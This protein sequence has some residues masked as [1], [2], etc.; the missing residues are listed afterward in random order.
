[1]QLFFLSCHCKL[2][3]FGEVFGLL[4]RQNIKY[5]NMTF[6]EYLSFCEGFE[7]YYFS[8]IKWCCSVTE[9]D[10]VTPLQSLSSDPV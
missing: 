2:N 1:M 8:A 9:M 10:A 3:N 7:N 4:V 5:E 6:D